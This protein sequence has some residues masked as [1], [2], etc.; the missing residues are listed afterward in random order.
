MLGFI[1][2]YHIASDCR[3]PADG[4]AAQCRSQ[5]RAEA[6]TQEKGQNGMLP[7]KGMNFLLLLVKGP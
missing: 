5:E 6:A 7:G 2:P 1:L 3:Q 4:P